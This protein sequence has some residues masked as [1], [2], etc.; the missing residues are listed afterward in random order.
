M[1]ADEQEIEAGGQDNIQVT[2]DRLTSTRK[3]RRTLAI[4]LRMDRTMSLHGVIIKTSELLQNDEVTSL[5]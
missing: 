1:E 2:K 5:G 3:F 4:I